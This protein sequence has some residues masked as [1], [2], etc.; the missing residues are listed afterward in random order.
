MLVTDAMPSVG[1][2]KKSFRLQGHDIAVTDG[3]CRAAD[4]TLTGSDLDMISA[5]RNSMT[6]M[7][8]LLPE[9]IQMASL[10]PASFLRLSG[11][12]G[13]IARGLRADFVVLDDRYQ[14]LETWIGGQ[15]Q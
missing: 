13:A 1:A 12:T 11:R 14:I 3:V 15:S 7:G 6:M 8:V 5:V 10:N 9:A 2:A 4:G